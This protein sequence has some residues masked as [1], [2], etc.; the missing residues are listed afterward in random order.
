MGLAMGCKNL[1][2]PGGG[3]KREGEVDTSLAIKL[4]GNPTEVCINNLME[5]YTQTDLKS[6]P[7]YIRF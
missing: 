7:G 1:I 5:K 3:G 2:S 6:K 4:K